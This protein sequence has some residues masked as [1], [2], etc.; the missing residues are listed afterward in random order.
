MND[1]ASF[2]SF[3][4]WMVDHGAAVVDVVALKREKYSLLIDRRYEAWAHTCGTPSLSLFARRSSGTTSSKTPQPV[5]LAARAMSFLVES[6][7]KMRD[8]ALERREEQD[9]M[10]ADPPGE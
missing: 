7:E 9:I 8:R 6:G 1:P 5:P 4:S 10:P 2:V 3:R